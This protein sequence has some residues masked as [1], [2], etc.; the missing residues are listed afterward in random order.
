MAFMRTLKEVGG[1]SSPGLFRKICQIPF[2]IPETAFR[3]LILRSPVAATFKPVGGRSFA[4]MGEA[5][6]F[7]N[8]PFGLAVDLAG[9]ILTIIA[10]V[11]G[12]SE[13]Y[14]KVSESPRQLRFFSLT[15]RPRWYN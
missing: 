12:F 1:P 4:A 15:S 8:S 7:Q 14:N 13:N 10:L 9:L 2:Q 5:R 6:N 3:D 11:P